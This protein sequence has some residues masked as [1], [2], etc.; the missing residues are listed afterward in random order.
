[1]RILKIAGK[2]NESRLSKTKLTNEKT[3]RTNQ[4]I[5]TQKSFINQP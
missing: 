3:H 5:P 2:G 1:M 4:A